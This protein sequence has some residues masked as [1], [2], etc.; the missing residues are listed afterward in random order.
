MIRRLLPFLAILY[1]VLMLYGCSEHEYNEECKTSGTSLI[2]TFQS[3]NARLETRGIEDLNDDGTVSELESVID[4]RRMYRLAVFLVRDAKVVASAVLEDGDARLSNSNTEATVSFDNLDYSRPYQ[5]YA[6]ANY[7]KYGTETVGHLSEITNVTNSIQIAS[8]TTSALCPKTTPYPLT[9]KKEITLQPG[10]NFVSG[11]LQRTYARI[12][13]NIRNQSSKTLQV[14][15]LSFANR[16]TQST[17]DLFTPGGAA[18]ATPVV[19]SADALIPFVP[20]MEIVGMGNDGKVTEKTIFDSYILESNGGTY[21]YSLKIKYDGGNVETLYEVNTAN[22]ITK[23]SQIEDGGMY[24][25]YCTAA[26]KYLYSNGT[27]NVKASSSYLNSDGTLNHNYVW[28]F[29]KAGN[30]NVRIES[31]G[32]TGYYMNASGITN[33]TIPLTNNNNQETRFTLSQ[34]TYG[35]LL[36]KSYSKNYYVSVSSNDAV[37]ASAGNYRRFYLYKVEGG[38]NSMSQMHQA[39]IPIKT[40]DKQSGETSPI[41]KIGRNDFLDILVNVTYNEKEGKIEFGVADWDEIEGDVTFD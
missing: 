35:D 13:L 36:M 2:V 1:S 33:K 21:E 6:V 5:L 19:T 3:A 18:N 12:R 39:T 34:H 30:S 32:A 26:N 16:F 29:T 31:M 22:A 20:N 9:L 15:D 40:I 7:G 27:A 11:E 24:V 17:A 38:S 25:L 14:A 41:E 23:Y 8:S 37:G 10:T 28:K 4:G